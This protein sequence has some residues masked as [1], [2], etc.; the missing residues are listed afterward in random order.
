MNKVG[1]KWLVL[2]SYAKKP[3][4]YFFIYISS[5]PN[6]SELYYLDRQLPST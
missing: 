2:A 3:L 6:P 1:M 4:I 5:V